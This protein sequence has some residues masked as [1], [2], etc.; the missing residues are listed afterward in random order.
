MKRY[1]FFA[2]FFPPAF[3]NLTLV[4]ARPENLA[5]YLV[6]GYVAATVPAMLIALLDEALER[7]KPAV[8]A[9]WCGLAGGLST[10]A[11]FWLPGLSTGAVPGLW[12]SLEI[13]VFGGVAA[14]LCVV[15]FSKMS[16]VRVLVRPEAPTEN[17]AAV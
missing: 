8:R 2:L 16:R 17:A 1:F 11:T 6:A 13:T 15:A 7:R 4:A 14:F 3:M 9:S 10:L 5:L 12:Q